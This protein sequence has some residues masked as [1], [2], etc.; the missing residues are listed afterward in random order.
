MNTSE[1]QPPTRGTHQIVELLGDA[2]LMSQDLGKVLGKASS[3]KTCSC[4]VSSS[5][6]LRMCQES[7][8]TSCCPGSSELGLD[9]SSD[10]LLMSSKADKTS[11]GIKVS[12]LVPPV[13]YIGRTKTALQSSDGLLLLA[14]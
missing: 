1:Q 6:V 9:S 7:N 12:V 2:Q 13:I 10:N 11:T 4:S 8:K 3:Y 5:D 14:K